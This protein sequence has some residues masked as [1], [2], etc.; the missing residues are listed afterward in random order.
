MAEIGL[1]RADGQRLSRR[2]PAPI[3]GP[4]GR[5]LHRITHRRSGAVGL[6]VIHLQRRNSGTLQ[7]G[8]HE[9]RLTLAAGNGD[10]RLAAAIG[11][12]PGGQYHRLNVITVGDGPV[13]QLQKQDRAPFRAHVAVSRGVERPA[14]AGRREHRGLGEADER[15]GVKKQ[16]DAADQ[17]GRRLP[18]AQ[19]VAC[20]V[21]RNQRRGAGGVHRHRRPAQ[22][23]YVG[24]TVGGNAER[25]ARHGV[26]RHAGKVI[27]P[28]DAVIQTGNA[29]IDGA[30]GAGEGG[31]YLPAVLHRLPGEFEQQALLGIKPSGFARRN[32]K[33]GGIEL[34]DAGQHARRE[35]DAASWLRPIRMLQRIDRPALETKLADDVPPRFQDVPETLLVAQVAGKAES[36]PD[37]SD[38]RYVLLILDLQVEPIP[39]DGHERPLLFFRI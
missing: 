29:Y 37:D 35:G 9:L 34:F 39:G 12:G 31:R 19:A 22:V 33:E 5:R 14:A 32:T 7:H 8:A 24:Q 17:R 13:E 28:A 27:Q 36:H 11:V 15:I 10:S 18:R 16:I 6:D 2:P 1:D 25:I 26:G 20:V 4:D 30:I 38:G 3:D 21:Q 23:E